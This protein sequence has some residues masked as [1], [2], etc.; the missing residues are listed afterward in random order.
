MTGQ[1]FNLLTVI[2]QNEIDY[3]K[4]NGKHEALWCCLCDCGNKEYTLA[5]SYQLKNGHKKSCGCLQIENGKKWGNI[6][7]D[8]LIHNTKK[9][10]QYDLSGEYGIGYIEDSNYVFYFDLDDYDK[11][12]NY[13]WVKT[14]EGYISSRDE[15]GKYIYMH[16]LVMNVYDKNIDVDHIKHIIFDNR[17]SQLRLVTSS[18]NNMNHVMQRNNTSGY[19]GVYFYKRTQQ[20]VAYIKINGKQYRKYCKSKEEA[21]SQRKKLE[22]KYFMDYSYENSMKGDL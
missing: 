5:K 19:N 2:K 8:N 18:Q 20:W 7:S 3:V 21:I 12:K 9:Y 6:N 22:E 11:I 13:Y 16:R 1:K 14:N 15:C 4:K 17:K 10:N